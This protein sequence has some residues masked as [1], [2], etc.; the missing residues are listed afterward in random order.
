M[1]CR[2]CKLAEATGQVF[3]LCDPCFDAFERAIQ[4]D[5]TGDGRAIPT[6]AELEY[7]NPGPWIRRP[8]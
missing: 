2:R 6:D 4:R 5:D 1:R 8:N 7:V 3:A